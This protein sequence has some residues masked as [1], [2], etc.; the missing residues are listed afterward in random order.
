MA[1][2]PSL[3]PS[4]SATKPRH[5][6]GYIV[7]LIVGLSLGVLTYVR[8]ADPIGDVAIVNVLTLIMAF[9]ATMALFVWFVAIST[10]PRWMRIASV[11]AVAIPLALFFTFN[12]IER[13]SG[14]LIPQ[15]RPRFRP[16]RDATLA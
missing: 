8:L 6:P 14:S 7:W 10:Y 12:K 5:F 1:L 16:P 11:V 9:I 4:P 2:V 13:V 15:F 3:K